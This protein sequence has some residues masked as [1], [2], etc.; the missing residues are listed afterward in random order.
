MQAII[1]TRIACSTSNTIKTLSDTS[2]TQNSTQPP[3]M[4]VSLPKI[5]NVDAQDF[6]LPVCS[7]ESPA[8]Q[9]IL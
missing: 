7:H 1:F 2:E 9:L 6:V 4:H 8:D 5:V 3:S